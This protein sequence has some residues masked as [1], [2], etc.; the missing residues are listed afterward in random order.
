MS[1]EAL[2]AALAEYEAVSTRYVA[3][4]ED[5]GLVFAEKGAPSC[6]HSWRRAAWPCAT[7]APA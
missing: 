7:R 2:D 6:A 3:T 5:K 4:L 1:N